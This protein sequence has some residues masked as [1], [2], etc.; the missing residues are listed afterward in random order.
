[1]WIE[2]ENLLIQVVL[3]SGRNSYIHVWRIRGVVQVIEATA[4]TY[5]QRKSNVKKGSKS[6]Q[7]G[8]ALAKEA[9]GA[10]LDCSEGFNSIGRPIDDAASSTIFVSNHFNKFD[11]VLKVVTVTEAATGQYNKS[12]YVESMRTE[13]ADNA[14][15]LDGTSFMSRILKVVRKIPFQQEAAPISTSWPRVIRDSS[16]AASR[17]GSVSFL[18]GIPSPYRP[19]FVPEQIS[20]S[21]KMDI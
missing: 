6:V 21:P 9:A 13:A 20:T 8:D 17:F 14:L 11:D 12:T 19:L 16:F 4:P 7:D 10:E 2:D 1:M 5:T 15:S 3:Y 18:R